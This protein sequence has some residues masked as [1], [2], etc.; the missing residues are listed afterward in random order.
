MTALA[1]AMALL[2]AAGALMAA[3]AYAHHGYA[4][5]VRLYVATVTVDPRP[6]GWLIR[7]AVNDSASGKPAP[8]FLVHAT[9][10]GPQGATFGRVTLTDPDADGRYDTALGPL[11]TGD[12]S[13]TVEVGDAPGS[14]ERA[15]PITRTRPVTL[16]TGAPPPE[17]GAAPPPNRAAPSSS[18]VGAVSA[19]L[20]GASLAVLLAMVATWRHRRRSLSAAT[21]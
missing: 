17:A 4:G 5:P 16:A 11:P 20:G 21:N 12:W 14:D 19:L 2:V 8:G 3:P 10:S 15:I 13:V 18:G 1:R 7:A 9:G 6:D